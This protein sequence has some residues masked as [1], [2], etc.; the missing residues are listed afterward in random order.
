M[1]PSQRSFSYIDFPSHSSHLSSYRHWQV[2]LHLPPREAILNFSIRESAWLNGKNY[3]PAANHL[4]VQFD[5]H[6]RG[7]VGGFITWEVEN[8]KEPRYLH[9]GRVKE[10][11]SDTYYAPTGKLFVVSWRTNRA[12]DLYGEHAIHLRDDVRKPQTRG[13]KRFD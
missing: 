8:Q 4:C 7:D 2:L 1:S 10:Q 6:L 9:S 12:K 11:T 13:E 3:I 5:G